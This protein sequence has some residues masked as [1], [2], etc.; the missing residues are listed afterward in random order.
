M[1]IFGTK[2]EILAQLEAFRRFNEW[3]E[4]NPIEFAPEEALE[5]ADEL[6]AMLAPAARQRVDDPRRNGARSMLKALARLR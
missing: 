5:L 6:Y 2:E 3:E 4:K 1:S